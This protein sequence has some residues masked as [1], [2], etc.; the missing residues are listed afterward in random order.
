MLGS[1]AIA[2]DCELC[3][4]S[5][6]SRTQCRKHDCL[7]K[8]RK[9]I[10]DISADDV[11]DGTS[12]EK[13]KMMKNDVTI[14][15]SGTEDV[16]DDKNGATKE[17]VTTMK[18]ITSS[19]P[20]TAD[21]TSNKMMKNDVT[22]SV[23]GT[24][25]VANI[26]KGATKKHKKKKKHVAIPSSSTVLHSALDKADEADEADEAI[27][28]I[29]KQ[30]IKQDSVVRFTA[31]IHV[32]L[33]ELR[34]VADALT[35]AKSQTN[36]GEKA[37]ATKVALEAELKTQL[38]AIAALYH[39]DIGSDKG[40]ALWKNTASVLILTYLYTERAQT[41]H[42]SSWRKTQETE[43]TDATDEE[44]KSYHTTNLRHL[45]QAILKVHDPE[46]ILWYVI[47]LLLV[48]FCINYL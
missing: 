13:K 24:E 35:K 17:K 2:Q 18:Q 32:Y 19:V 11:V 30:F 34:E 40:Q 45:V 4:L 42:A 31:S 47:I 26:K 29:G 39:D 38:Q 41:L 8:K 16:A 23:S 48:T 7:K 15:V 12:N 25:D 9:T 37:A 10:N 46:R 28:A 3:G 14:S 6:P 21:G 27:V 44:I 20:L 36:Y 5:F 33:K 43:I 1:T 22:I